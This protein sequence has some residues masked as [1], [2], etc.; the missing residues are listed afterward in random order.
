MGNDI[1]PMDMRVPELFGYPFSSARRKLRVTQMARFICTR[2]SDNLPATEAESERRCR[3][4]TG[5]R[6]LAKGRRLIPPF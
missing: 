3:A 4:V 1:D 2:A 6:N 5:S